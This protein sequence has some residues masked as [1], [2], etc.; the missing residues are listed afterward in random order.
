M[1]ALTMKELL[2]VSGGQKGGDI[3]PHVQR[4]LED[5]Y[6]NARSN[7]LSHEQALNVCRTMGEGIELATGKLFP[8]ASEGIY[9]ACE[10]GARAR[11]DSLDKS[12][13][14]ICEQIE[15]GIWDSGSRTCVM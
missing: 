14:A 7:G 3:P 12:A 15:G 8:G 11:V 1:K 5:A 6:R 2:A 13:S 4:E 10:I 9:A